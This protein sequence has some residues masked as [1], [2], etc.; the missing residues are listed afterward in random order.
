MLRQRAGKG[1][2]MNTVMELIEKQGFDCV[3]TCAASDLKVLE[4]VRHMCEADRCHKYGKTWA[5]PPGCGDIHDIERQMHEYSYCAVVQ[6]VGQL[7]D[8]FDGETIIETSAKQ[9]ERF[10]KLLED[11]DAAGLGTEVMSLSTA[12]CRNCKTCTYPDEPC[13]FP[14]KRFVSMS[15]S[16]VLVAETCRKAGIPYNYGKNTIAYTSCVLYN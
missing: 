13:R 1:A 14:D 4:E 7:E 3:G 11:L 15:A 16:G 2:F 9:N 6:S 8:E 10:Y 5:C 12:Q